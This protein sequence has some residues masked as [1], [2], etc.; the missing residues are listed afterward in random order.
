MRTEF[1]D[2][3][4]TEM[5]Q[6]EVQPRPG[7]VREAYHYQ[8]RRQTAR[9]RAA[10]A[11]VGGVAAVAAA[12]IVLS[13]LGPARPL[14][15]SSARPAPGTTAAGR[16][17]PT[18]VPTWGPVVTYSIRRAAGNVTV[19]DVLTR[20]ANAIGSQGDPGT[21]WPAGAYWHTEQQVTS[22]GHPVSTDNTWISASGNGAAEGTGVRPFPIAGGGSAAIGEKDYTFAQL[23]ALPT[24]PAQLWPIVQADET[25]PFTSDPAQ[26]KSGQSDLFHSIWNL[27]GSYPVPAPLQQAL[28]EVAAKIP[29]V[30]VAGQY[31]D[32]LGRTG[33]ALSLGPWTMVV[34]PDTGQ[35]LALLSGRQPGTRVC[36]P[37]GCTWQ[38]GPGPSTVVYITA[39]W[40]AASSVPKVPQCHAATERDGG[41]VTT[42][43]RCAGPSGAASATGSK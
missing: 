10:F 29:G 38:K 21:S 1:E 17:L 7:L 41:A 39:G 24:D 20:A 34:D 13:S 33:T 40:V 5:G 19:A 31:T 32:S 15:G 2:R 9:R 30:T 42:I 18:S 35:L 12:G 4:R 3:L 37:S 22:A 14:A 43:L 28:Y 16:A 36:N 6:V 25:A 26:P 11:A 8:R 23:A 27:L